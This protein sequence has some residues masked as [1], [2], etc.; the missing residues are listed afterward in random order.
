[1]NGKSQS[2]L[3]LK[4]G[5]KHWSLLLY[6]TVLYFVTA[7]ITGTVQITVP[8]LVALRGWDYAT[9][10][11][12]NTIGGL[13]SIPV[14]FI[15]AQIIKVRGVKWPT[16]IMLAL[17]GVGMMLYGSP[18][19]VLYM[20]G[21]LV[22]NAVSNGLN[23]VSPNTLLTDWFP[24]KKG[25]VLGIATAGMMLSAIV[26]APAFQLI[27][28]RT[29][30]PNAFIV[31]GVVILVVAVLTLFIKNTP[32]EAGTY[33]DNDPNTDMAE[34]E[35]IKAALA[36]RNGWTIGKLLK[37]KDFWMITIGFG[38][39]FFALI[40]AAS[41]F[42]PQGMEY[43]MT[44]PKMLL[45]MT[46]SGIG[47]VIG[48]YLLGAIDQAVSTKLATVIYGVGMILGMATRALGAGS[49][50]LFYI[51]VFALPFFQGGLANL[52]IS[53]TIQVFGPASYASVN[54]I[55]SP[56]VI[57]IRTLSFVVVGVVYTKSGTY[58]VVSW[59]ITALLVVSLI[60]LCCINSKTKAVPGLQS[61]KA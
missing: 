8:G 10:M 41:F 59:V 1:M 2:K 6:T 20:V 47:S 32:K 50:P 38:L 22:A 19:F 45:L 56:L 48:S 49:I 43:G 25:V 13:L 15:F 42:L 29:G 57:A 39:G 34:V 16:V 12:F 61:E 58:S 27:A 21:V 14:T 44:Q 33:P 35:R 37:N 9:L 31:V 54:R 5:A 26:A 40:G 60:C 52:M 11:S 24:K 46:L 28:N 23:M 17:Y 4:F 7:I 36:G 3:S 53:M 18:V 30:L 55:M 51:G